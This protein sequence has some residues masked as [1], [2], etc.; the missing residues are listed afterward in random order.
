MS[1]TATQAGFAQKSGHG[2]YRDGGPN[3]DI[4]SDDS[5]GVVYDRK[6]VDTGRCSSRRQYSKKEIVVAVATAPVRQAIPQEGKEGEVSDDDCK[7]IDGRYGD[8]ASERKWSSQ[9]YQWVDSRIGPRVSQQ[10]MVDYNY[11]SYSHSVTTFHSNSHSVQ[12]SVAVNDA[13]YDSQPVAYTNAADRHVP[14]SKNDTQCNSYDS[15]GRSD[16]PDCGAF[17]K[18][19]GKRENKSVSASVTGRRMQNE[20][21]EKRGAWVRAI[22]AEE[23]AEAATNRISGDKSNRVKYV[24]DNIFN[25]DNDDDEEDDDSDEESSSEKKSSSQDESR[26]MSDTNKRQS[27]TFNRHNN[28]RLAAMGYREVFPEKLH[29]MLHDCHKNDLTHIASFTPAGDKFQI[30]N[31]KAFLS[32]VLPRYFHII[33]FPSFVRQLRIYDFNTVKE[34]PEAGAFY[35]PHFHRD[36]VDNISRIRRRYKRKAQANP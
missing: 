9:A 16:R 14:S 17:H 32:D 15:R 34:G 26:T 27:I 3:G 7:D 31:H 1:G 6:G 10:E 24:A 22:N 5:T 35:N 20:S 18:D 13:R 28:D 2:S 12:N 8:D 25:A 36:N 19:E 21:S 30:H 4:S 29:R 23:S 33:R 11:T